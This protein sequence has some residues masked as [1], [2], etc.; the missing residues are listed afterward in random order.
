[1]YLKKEEE[2]IRVTFLEERQLPKSGTTLPPIIST[3]TTTTTARVYVGNHANETGVELDP[4]TTRTTARAYI[5]KH[6][7]ETGLTTTTAQAYVSKL[8]P[9]RTTTARAY[10]G[11]HASK[12]DVKPDPT[13]TLTTTTRASYLD[14]LVVDA[15]V[16]VWRGHPGYPALE[17]RLCPV[18]HSLVL[19]PPLDAG[20]L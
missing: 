16:D 19:Q 8:D 20:R 7:S 15:P 1:M 10:V 3:T 12:T 13:T 2:E 5:N 18:P 14:G 11:N 17:H 4:T 9:T 6:A